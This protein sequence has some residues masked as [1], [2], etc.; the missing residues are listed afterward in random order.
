MGTKYTTLQLI[1]DL[2]KGLGGLS[3]ASTLLGFGSTYLS[4]LKQRITNSNVKGYNPK[5][6]FSLSNLNVFKENLER[7]IGEKGDF[8]LFMINK[9]SKCNND[10]KHYSRQ[11]YRSTLNP[12]YFKRIDTLEKAYWLGFLYADGE[13][14]NKYKEK[15]WY[16]IS[17]E[18]SVKDRDH[19]ENFCRAI[20]L[21]PAELIK[22]RERYKKYNNKIKKYRMAYVR[23]RC[24]P[25]VKDLLNIGFSS[26][27]TLKKSIPK[28]FKKSNDSTFGRKLSLAWLLGYYDGDGNSNSTRITSSSKNLLNEI[29]SEFNIKFDVKQQYDKGEK[30]RLDGV[31]STKPHWRLTLGASLFNEMIQN[32]Q[33]SM[34]RKRRIFKEKDMVSYNRLKKKV[35]NKEN[36]QY[37]VGTYKIIS[38]IKRFDVS[39]TTFYRLCKEWNINT[40]KMRNLTK[41]KIE[42]C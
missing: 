21:I 15:Y 3:Q 11:Q 26:S 2:E 28:I 31:I 32:Y 33:D 22:E 30:S 18:L 39:T 17:V 19:L 16:R 13:I 37:L 36:L 4:D 24:K 5:Y 27:K 20:G 40:P 23:F 12:N 1:N 41:K 35:L 34:K 7:N 42:L 8:C 9:Y 25:M 10:L 29:K 6:K 14:R 38:L